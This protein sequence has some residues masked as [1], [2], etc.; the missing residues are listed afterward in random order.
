M[1]ALDTQLLGLLLHHLDPVKLTREAWSCSCGH[2][3][4]NDPETAEERRPGHIQQVILASD[5]LRAVKAA[6]HLRPHP[7]TEP[8]QDP[9][10]PE[11]YMSGPECDYEAAV[12]EDRR[13]RDVER[14]LR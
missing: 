1:S 11:P 6:E 2:C 14:G 3:L 5:W 10:L 7:D 8:P 12:D 9:N 13:L 4:A